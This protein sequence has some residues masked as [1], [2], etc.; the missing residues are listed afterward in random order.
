MVTIKR[1]N[2]NFIFTIQGIHKLW[3]LKSEL[4]IPAEHIITAYP[5]AENLHVK[6][7]FRLPGTSIPGLIEAGSF[8][9]RNGIIFCD[10]TND[11]KNIVIELQHEHYTKLIIDV[12]DPGS[13]I[14]LLTQK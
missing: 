3:A 13:A 8:I 6:L 12:E 1:T 10:I 14:A 2:D 5:N 9:G 7:G 11:S 4:T